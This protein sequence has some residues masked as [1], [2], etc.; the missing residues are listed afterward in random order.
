MTLTLI[1]RPQLLA[2]AALPLLTAPPAAAQG[3]MS[4]SE[5]QAVRACMPDIRTY[6]SGVGRGG[7]RIVPCLRQ[8]GERLS[9]SCRQ[10]LSGL[11]R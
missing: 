9:P 6:C 11:Q 7:G 5:R 10:A 3:G 8:N 4:S 2:L 1:G